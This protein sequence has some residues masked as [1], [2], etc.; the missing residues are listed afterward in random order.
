MSKSFQ[1]WDHFLPLLFPKNSEYLKSLGIGLR[2]VGAKRPLNGV[3]KCDKQTNQ[4]T[5]KYMDI[6]TFR[7]NGPRRPILW[8]YG[9][10]LPSY[11]SHID[12]LTSFNFCVTLWWYGLQFQPH[13][14]RRKV[15]SKWVA[16]FFTD[17]PMIHNW[18]F[19]QEADVTP[20]HIQTILQGATVIY[21]QLISLD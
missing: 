15:F 19:T 20:L 2:E 16:V 17:C 21:I 18:G 14:R 6:L 13:K 3:R 11:L 5:D 12:K 9:I 7:M 10:S 8:K 1:I 4:Q